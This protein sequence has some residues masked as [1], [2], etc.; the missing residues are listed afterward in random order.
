MTTFTKLPDFPK[1]FLDEHIFFKCLF[2]YKGPAF[3]VKVYCIF[4][5]FR[6]A[7]FVW[8]QAFNDSLLDVII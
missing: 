2:Q 3:F 8:F 6:V 7:L 1:R 4:L 5:I